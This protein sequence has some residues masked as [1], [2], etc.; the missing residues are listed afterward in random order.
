MKSDAT[1]SD[2]KRNIVSDISS[3]IL[4]RSVSTSPVEI[5]GK[6]SKFV[7]HVKT[8]TILEVLRNDDAAALKGYI[9]QIDLRLVESPDV[10]VTVYRTFN[11]F[12]DLHMQLLAH[13]PEA[14]GVSSDDSLLGKPIERMLPEIP[15]QMMFVGDAVA[16]TRLGQLQDYLNVFLFYYR[17]C[18]HY[19]K[20]SRDVP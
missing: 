20:Q 18:W 8:A 17:Y 4:N 19:Q 14:A 13:F 1:G 16:L 6:N 7:K 15:L 9:Y 10:S 12:F 11:H 5:K 3:T 2:S